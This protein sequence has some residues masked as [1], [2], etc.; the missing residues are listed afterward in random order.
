MPWEKSRVP[1]SALPEGRS[2]ISPTR[3]KRSRRGTWTRRMRVWISHRCWCIPVTRWGPW[4]PVL[5]PCR[6]RSHRR[7]GLR[8][9]RDDLAA[10]AITDTLTGLPNRLLLL[11][12]MAEALPLAEQRGEGMALLMLDLDRFKEVNDTFG[13]QIGDHVKAGVIT[14][15]PTFW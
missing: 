11:E 5:T 4:R 8:Q 15:L 10:L 13:H 9:A 1:R 6:S 3:C 12:R 14:A 7:Q 2:P